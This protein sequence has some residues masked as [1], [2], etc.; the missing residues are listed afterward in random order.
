[1]KLL[2]AF[3][4]LL[5]LASRKHI[6]NSCILASLNFIAILEEERI[7]IARAISLVLP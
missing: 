1:M 5:L 4:S 3:G 6:L 2:N 7:Y